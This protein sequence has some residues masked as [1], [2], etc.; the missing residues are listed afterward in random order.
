MLHIPVLCRESCPYATIWFKAAY[1]GYCSVRKIASCNA[2]YQT[3]NFQSAHVGASYEVKGVHTTILGRE[4]F[5]GERLRAFGFLSFTQLPSL[6]SGMVRMQGGVFDAQLKP[7]H[8]WILPWSIWAYPQVQ[9]VL[10]PGWERAAPSLYSMS[11]HQ[12]QP[13][14]Q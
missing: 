1:P 12:R 6:T 7:R 3:P 13:G 10:S 14:S 8:P 4:C 2:S 5:H 9:T 11:W